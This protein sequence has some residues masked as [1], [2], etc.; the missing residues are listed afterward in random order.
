MKMLGEEKVNNDKIHA[1][2][3]EVIPD[4]EPSELGEIGKYKYTMNPEKQVNLEILKGRANRQKKVFLIDQIQ[5][6]LDS[7][8]LSKKPDAMGMDGNRG[9]NSSVMV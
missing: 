5:H 8:Q 1:K 7:V 4:S 9:R 2:M 6:L 3:H